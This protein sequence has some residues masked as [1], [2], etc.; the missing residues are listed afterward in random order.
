MMASVRRDDFEMRDNEP[1]AR[2]WRLRQLT[3]AG[4]P[5]AT[6]PIALDISE[7]S[8]RMQLREQ[9][10]SADVWAN[11]SLGAGLAIDD[12]P[13]GLLSVLQPA[14]ALRP[15]RYVYDLVMIRAGVPDVIVEGVITVTSG[16]TRSP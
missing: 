14:H 12:G 5:P 8:F 3:D 7:A 1:L 10:T 6:P 9:A 11:L 16:V 13:G 2:S 15:G 4:D